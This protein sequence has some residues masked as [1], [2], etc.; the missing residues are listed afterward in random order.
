MISTL[1]C[2]FRRP[3][4]ISSLQIIQAK[5]S[6]QF[7]TFFCEKNVKLAKKSLNMFRNIFVK[8]INSDRN[9]SA[10][11]FFFMIRNRKIQICSNTLNYGVLSDIF[12]KKY[13][14]VRKDIFQ[15]QKK[16]S[17]FTHET[18]KN[19]VFSEEVTKDV[20]N[21]LKDALS[22]AVISLLK[23]YNIT[24]FSEIKKTGP[25]GRLLKGDILAYVGVIGE[26]S[27]LKLLKV[28]EGKEK[29]VFNNVKTKFSRSAKHSITMI[30]I[31]VSLESLLSMEKKINEKLFKINFSNLVN[32]AIYKAFQN[33]PSIVL[34]KISHQEI[35]FSSILGETPKYYDN[36]NVNYRNF[37]SDYF[38]DK[39]TS[40]IWELPKNIRMGNTIFPSSL[41][42]TIEKI[43]EISIQDSK[44]FQKN[45]DIIDFLNKEQ[46]HKSSL[47][48]KK[49]ILQY[50]TFI[51]MKFDKSYTDIRVA[52]A[53]VN[54]LKKY[55][56]AP[57]ELLL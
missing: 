10:R 15:F 30:N 19:K 3:L 4:Y 32:K 22:P 46:P 26:D 24:D 40:V 51:R 23:H 21:N 28:L 44:G 53:Y 16:Q 43:H 39:K 37:E 9:F 13:F 29:L 47:P 12:T 56:E 8:N 41:F 31:P 18:V 49:N 14:E 54:E 11:C 6:K 45:L 55:L 17:I 52:K 50:T 38:K 1:L 36:I 5:G 20:L 27:P 33:V 25:R 48:T 35:L 57:E 7:S 34:K 2:S 42:L